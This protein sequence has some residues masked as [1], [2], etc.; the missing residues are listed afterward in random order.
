MLGS[1]IN[2]LKRFPNQK[3]TRENLLKRFPNKKKNKKAQVGETLTWIVATLII[4][5]TLFIF[6]Y[7]SIA[8]AEVKSVNSIRIKSESRAVWGED[9]DW[10]EI[11]NRMAFSRETSNRNKIERW[12]SEKQES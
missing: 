6:I 4:I 10:I 8:M 11:K 7:A 9:V 3:L 5:T 1:K 2:L 12:I